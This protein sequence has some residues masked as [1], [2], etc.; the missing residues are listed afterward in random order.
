[1]RLDQI[2]TEGITN[3]FYLLKERLR[4]MTRKLRYLRNLILA[5]GAYVLLA[6]F[7]AVGQTTTDTSAVGTWVGTLEA[8]GARLRLVLHINVT[9]T[10]IFTG[11]VDS[12]DKSIKGIPLSRVYVNG[13]SLVVSISAALA[14][15]EGKLS[16]KKTTIE[17][18]WKEDGASFPMVLSRTIGTIDSESI[19]GYTKNRSD[20]LNLQKTSHHFN[21]YSSDTDRKALDDIAKALEDNYGRI[22]ALLHTKF[23][24]RIKVYVY[25]DVKTF[26]DAIYMPNTPDWV[27]GAAGMNELKM[28]SPLNPGSAHS[29]TSLIQAIVHELTHAVVLNA[30][31]ERGLAGLPKWLNEGFAFYEARQMNEEMRRTVIAHLSEKTLPTWMELDTANVI[32]FGN[33]DGYALSTLIIEF[34]VNSYGFEKMQRLIM[35]PEK[36]DAIYGLSNADLEKQWVQYLK[37]I[38]LK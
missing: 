17:G 35:T 11:T 31:T 9:D 3:I 6:L 8:G 25:P 18:I 28:V 2:D 19:H 29:Y 24:N 36:M 27:V 14:G 15:Y 38:T 22:A 26:H 5:F 4:K 1:V 12:P 20:S 33:M 16:N 10:G 21:L 37:T 7:T 34:L 30:R 23:K 13:D 32:E